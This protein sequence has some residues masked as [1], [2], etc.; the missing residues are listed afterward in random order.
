VTAAVATERSP[1]HQS[2][3]DS[4]RSGNNPQRGTAAD[5][6]GSSSG[7]EAQ[8]RN[9]REPLHKRASANSGGD[10]APNP[11]RSGVFA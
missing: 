5:R 9:E 4:A 11:S 1:A 3:S 2:E 10:Q 6:E 7:R 8:S